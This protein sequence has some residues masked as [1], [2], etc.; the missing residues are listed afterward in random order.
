MEKLNI[1]LDSL[2]QAL[3]MHGVDATLTAPDTFTVKGDK[4][5]FDGWWLISNRGKW[6]L[7]TTMSVL[8]ILQYLGLMRRDFRTAANVLLDYD[9]IK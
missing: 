8:L 4:F 9:R 5:C 2:T 6:P 1:D 7:E 3:R